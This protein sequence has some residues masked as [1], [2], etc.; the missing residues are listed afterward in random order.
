MALLRK[1]SLGDR[2]DIPMSAMID[3]VFLLLIYFIV[4]YQEEIPEAHLQVN[5]PAPDAVER[6]PEDIPDPPLSLTVLPRQYLV[7]GRAMEPERIRRY[8]A[9]LA[10]QAGPENVTVLINTHVT[11]PTR[12]LIE[13]LDICRSV[14]ITRLN[15]MTIE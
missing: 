13:I 12:N 15:V 5:L 4:T 3:V 9:G 10:Q 14:Q 8:L 11:A 2:I 1:K 6:D 7:E